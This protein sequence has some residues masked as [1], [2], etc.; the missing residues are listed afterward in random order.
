VPG[1]K[2][3]SKYLHTFNIYN[4]TCPYPHITNVTRQVLYSIDEVSCCTAAH[5]HHGLHYSSSARS[6]PHVPFAPRLSHHSLS[7]HEWH[8]YS[9]LCNICWS[10]NTTADC[11]SIIMIC[12]IIAVHHI[13]AC[14]PASIQ[15]YVITPLLPEGERR[16]DVVATLI[17][18]EYIVCSMFTFSAYHLSTSHRHLDS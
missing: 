6:L 8:E 1:L 7:M 2:T 5:V 11:C 14:V 3:I 15:S 4:K 17:E 9:T 18:I 13:T 10:T 16:D 12:C